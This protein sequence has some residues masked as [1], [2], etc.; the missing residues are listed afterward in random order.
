M[1]LSSYILTG[2]GCYLVDVT[3]NWKQHV[4][5]T[6]KKPVLYTAAFLLVLFL[7]PIPLVCN[8]CVVIASM[9][10]RDSD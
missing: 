9:F 5:D 3:I 6:N 8:L 2:V 7:W 1:T 4:E 10:E